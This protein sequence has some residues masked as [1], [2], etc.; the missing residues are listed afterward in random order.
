[1]PQSQTAA[2]PRHQEV[3]EKD[4]KHT[5]AKETNV[6]EAQRPTPSSP[7]EVIRMLK[8]TETRG[9]S[10]REDLKQEISLNKT[11]NGADWIEKWLFNIANCHHFVYFSAMWLV[12]YLF[13]SSIDFCARISELFSFRRLRKSSILWRNAPFQ[14]QSWDYK[15]LIV[16]V[17]FIDVLTD[18]SFKTWHKALLG[19][20]QFVSDSPEFT[21]Q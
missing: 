8:Q 1:M 3:E 6:R 9:Q 5:P 18:E 10:A 16:F 19:Y 14:R 2:N 12:E 4:K 20:A 17:D 21:H 15:G 11:I 7:S 13:Y